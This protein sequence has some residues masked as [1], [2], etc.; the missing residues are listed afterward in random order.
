MLA[1]LNCLHCHDIPHLNLKP[2]KI[3]WD[4]DA[5]YACGYRFCLSWN[6]HPRIDGNT[7]AYHASEVLAFK[8]PEFLHGQLKTKSDIW[9]LFAIIVW[10]YDPQEFQENCSGGSEIFAW[11]ASVAQLPQFSRI[12]GMAC[13]D[14]EY[15]PSAHAQLQILLSWEELEGQELVEEE[16]ENATGSENVHLNTSAPELPYYEPFISPSSST[17]SVNL[18]E[19]LGNEGSCVLDDTSG[20]V[21]KFPKQPFLLP[22]DT[23]NLAV[24]GNIDEYETVTTLGNSLTSHYEGEAPT[25]SGNEIKQVRKI[26]C[27]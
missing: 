10:T 8:A 15:R 12:R 20:E 1:A 4:E 26:Y 19:G 7:L 23:G 9:S 11:L 3:L 17:T 27:L 14:P 6:I 13:L 5:E 21:D 2:T 22:V 18:G 24:S 16:K 25:P